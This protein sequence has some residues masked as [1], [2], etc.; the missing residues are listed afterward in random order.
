MASNVRRSQI[1]KQVLSLYK[2]CLRAAE[3]K[4]PGFKSVVQAQFK[5]NATNIQ[6]SDTMRIEYLVRQG[7]RRLEMMKVIILQH[8]SIKRFQG[9]NW[10][11]GAANFRLLD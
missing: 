6:R 4:N 7:R 9:E 3:A 1:Q 10:R 5:K 11:R 8:N 2:E